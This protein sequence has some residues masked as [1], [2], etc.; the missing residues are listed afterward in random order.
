[1]FAE[2]SFAGCY[3]SFLTAVVPSLVGGATST[4]P[5]A[6]VSVHATRIRS[7]AAGVSVEGFSETFYRKGRPVRSAFS[8][9]IDVIASGR[10]IAVLETIA[11]QR[12]PAAEGLNLLT[13]VEQNVAG[14]SSS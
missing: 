2:R 10:I 11:S 6:Y 9:G 13:S 8:G 7:S 12:F 4:I 14:E 1:M 5:F 3:S